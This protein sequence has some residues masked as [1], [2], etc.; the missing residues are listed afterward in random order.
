MSKE[1]FF[2]VDCELLN[3]DVNLEKAHHLIER[4]VNS[5][6]LDITKEGTGAE[7][8]VFWGN[9]DS[10]NLDAG[11]IGDY[12]ERAEASLERLREVLKAWAQ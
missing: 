7:I 6:E 5:Y 10:M 1:N 3:L 2:D 8:A 12:I 9:R 4:F 11:I